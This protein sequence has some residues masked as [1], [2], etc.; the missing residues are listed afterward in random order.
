MNMDDLFAV[1]KQIEDAYKLEN[2]KVADGWNKMIIGLIVL[3]LIV[4]WVG[5]ALLKK[6]QSSITGLMSMLIDL[7]VILLPIAII[8]GC[9]YLMMGFLMQKKDD[10]KD[11][12]NEY[13]KKLNDAI[14]Y[15]CF[16]RYFIC[17]DFRLKD[18]NSKLLKSNENGEVEIDFSDMLFEDL[19]FS[20]KIYKNY[21]FLH[22]PLNS[23]ISDSFNVCLKST[24]DP[25]SEN[26]R[27]DNI[28][29]GS[30]NVKPYEFNL[31]SASDME[32]GKLNT[33]QFDSL[34]TTTYSDR[35]IAFRVLSPVVIEKLLDFSK[36]F[37][38]QQ[39]KIADDE[40]C[41][42]LEKK[43]A[44]LENDDETITAQGV[45]SSARTQLETL[46]ALAKLVKKIQQYEM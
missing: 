13:K 29:Y 37:R 33:N 16:E 9:I 46:A 36:Q 2:K 45:I 20:Y 5:E 44:M 11:L 21:A 35:I 41:F 40:V 14:F 27:N 6:A 15:D 18:E 22:M 30:S 3:A 26:I 23:N 42:E 28:I 4:F 10:Q 7:L 38:I 39:V 8:G 32:E 19:P 24:K 25:E 43:A 31:V 12:K 17:S 34:F 1:G